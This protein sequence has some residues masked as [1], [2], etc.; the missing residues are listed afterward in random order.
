MAKYPRRAVNAT[1]TL[2]TRTADDR[3][4]FGGVTYTTADT[5]DDVVIKSAEIL[6]DPPG[7]GNIPTLTI[8]VLTDPLN[9][10]PRVDELATINSVVYRI[11]SVEATFWKGINIVDKVSLLERG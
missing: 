10:T 5:S 8:T 1:M 11:V 2:T 9:L 3:D 4:T 7:A 6:E